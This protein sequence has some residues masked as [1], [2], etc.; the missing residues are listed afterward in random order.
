MQY[1]LTDSRLAYIFANISDAV[2]ITKKNGEI[3]HVNASATKLSREHV[4]MTYM[5]EGGGIFVIV[6]RNLTELVRVNEAFA[7]YTSPEI[8]KYVLTAPEGEKQG[9]Q[10]RDVSIL[11]SY[12]R[13]FTAM[14]T[15]LHPDTLIEILN[16]YFEAMLPV[17]KRYRGTVIEFLGDGIFVVFGAPNDD[18][19][20]AEHA[21]F[22]AV[23]MQNAMKS[24]NDWNVLRGYPVLEIGIGINSGSAI[25]G[26]IGSADKMKYGCIGETVNLAGRVEA[27]TVGGQV[28]I[29]ER[30]RARINAELKISAEQSF[31]PKGAAEPIKFFAVDGIGQEHITRRDYV[32]RGTVNRPV[33]TFFKVDGKNIAG[34]GYTCEIVS[35][36]S[37]ER[38]AVIET[39]EPV[40]AMQNIVIDI[41]GSL[42][43]KALSV[44]TQR[45]TISFTSKPDNFHDWLKTLF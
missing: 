8:A 17:I 6:V 14:S 33:A 28:Y 39:E 45:I 19:S 10:T 37:D 44:S 24:V 11:M 34:E 36:S 27:F 2:C 25:V 40:A 7:R 15:K 20:H 4:N 22:C 18:D 38:Y 13:G 21:V 41:G 3:I 43:A 35:V 26:N 23:G 12:L 1:A 5:D 16:H 9:G 32:M 42:Y 29:S 30:T 31:M